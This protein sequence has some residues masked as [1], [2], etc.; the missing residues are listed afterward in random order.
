LPLLSTGQTVDIENALINKWIAEKK[1]D[2]AGIQERAKVWKQERVN[3]PVVP[4]DSLSGKVVTSQVIQYSGV[5]KS[6]AFKRTMEWAALRFNKVASVVEYSDADAGKLVLEGY[7]PIHFMGSFKNIWG[8]VK[9]LPRSSDLHFS[10]VI[11]LV[12]GKAKIEYHN[13]HFKTFVQGFIAGN[14]YVPSEIVRNNFED[15]FPIIEQD[16]SMWSGTFDLVRKSLAELNA[17]GPDLSRFLNATN[18]DYK[19]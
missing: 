2:A 18:L 12:E 11:T 10:M 17:T 3:Y 8:N 7:V 19:F 5:S 6:Q 4:F 14:V 9:T 15:M 13:L 16:F 1:W